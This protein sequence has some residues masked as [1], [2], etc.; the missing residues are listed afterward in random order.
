MGLCTLRNVW[1]YDLM[2]MNETFY[3]E[4]QMLCHPFPPKSV[5]YTSND[6]VQTKYETYLN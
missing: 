4:L 3:I 2:Q 6:V 5:N 1:N